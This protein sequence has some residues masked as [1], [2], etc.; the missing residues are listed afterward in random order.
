MF[1][2]L[3]VL[4][5]RI[6]LFFLKAISFVLYE[7]T[8]SLNVSQLKVTEK[9]INH[10]FGN[11]QKLIHKSFKETIELSLLF[12]FVWGKRNNYKSLIDSDYLKLQSLDNNRP[13]L[14]FTLHMGCVDILVFV[15]SE[16]FPQIDVL[17][18]PAKNHALEKELLKIRQRQGARMFPSTTNGVTGL[19]KSFLDKNNV[20]V[21]SDLVPHEKGIYEQFF[22]KE[23]FCLD[24]I[25][26]LSKKG[27][28]DLHLI[29]LTK[30]NQK[31]YKVV[32]KKIK[33]QINTAEMNKF[34]EEAVLTAPELYGWE[35]K[36]FRKLRPNK[37]NIY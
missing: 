15:L 7:V 13:K 12:P 4:I 30:G 37:S 6:P 1:S 17:Y 25:E 8:K 31:K 34:F 10:C 22:D 21:A 20:L 28:H 19:F 18:T 27:T 36:K 9:N 24:L 23:C 32:C 11:D 14:F 16:L 33:K 35:Y 3:F 2:I 5:S 26:K 29:Y